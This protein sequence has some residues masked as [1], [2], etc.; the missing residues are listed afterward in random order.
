MGLNGNIIAIIK[1][2]HTKPLSLQ[3]HKI[4]H[5]RESSDNA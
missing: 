2:T 5:V 1:K 3:S 4:D